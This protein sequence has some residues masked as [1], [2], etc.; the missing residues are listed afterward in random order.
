MRYLGGKNALAKPIAK[1]VRRYLDDG[2]YLEPFCGSCSVAALIAQSRNTLL[3]CVEDKD[4]RIV[5]TDVQPDL[6]EMWKA[7]QHGWQPPETVTEEQ[8]RFW[9]DKP[10][11]G[12][13]RGFVGF[14]CSFGG[15]F[16]G[17]YAQDRRRGN[18]ALQ[19]RNTLR[20]KIRLLS[21]AHFECMDYKAAIRKH[22]PVVMYCDPP[23]SDTA[24]YATTGNF[25]NEE[26]WQHMREESRYRI[27]LVSEYTAPKDFHS[28][29]SVYKKSTLDATEN[30]LE[31]CEH[32][33]KWN[34]G[35]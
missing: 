13:M 16:F 11:P 19:S 17:G 23:Y 24:G 5:C 4:T 33:Y 18:Y 3:S 12:K 27:I 32:V 35:V 14:G 6:I 26:F 29:L 25:N 7:L 21:T 30:K 9:R 15:K 1:M 22:D 8:Y 2:L 20:K 10:R 34:G 28:I 31:V